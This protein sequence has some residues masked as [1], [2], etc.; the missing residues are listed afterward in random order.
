LPGAMR[1]VLDI[2]ARVAPR[3]LT[4]LITGES[5]V[6]KERL[7]RL[8]HDASPRRG[9]GPFVAVHCGAFSDTLFDGELFGHIRGA[10]T[11][12]T[13]DCRGVF[14]AADGETRARPID[15]RVIAATN[16]D[17]LE[18]IAQERFRSD[19]Y[20][21]AP[22]RAARLSISKICPIAFVSVGILWGIDELCLPT[23]NAGT[24]WPS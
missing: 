2:V 15:V 14:E 19:L 4:V 11:G 8:L 24:S 1:R 13:H 3:D 5:G 23:V 21:R 12:A 22:S 17:L 6:G 18:E 7:A 20:Y 9:S 10:F 16:R